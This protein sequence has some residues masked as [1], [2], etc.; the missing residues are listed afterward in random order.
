VNV[1]ETFKGS[2]IGANGELRMR[3]KMNGI[4]E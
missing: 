1:L 4:A 3:M 2:Q